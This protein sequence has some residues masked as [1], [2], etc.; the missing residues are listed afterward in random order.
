M[1]TASQYSK[2]FNHVVSSNGNKSKG[3]YLK[4]RR[5]RTLKIPDPALKKN[6]TG[7]ELPIPSFS[8]EKYAPFSECLQRAK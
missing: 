5:L 7:K 8:P 1:T 6:N 2:S 4:N 3:K